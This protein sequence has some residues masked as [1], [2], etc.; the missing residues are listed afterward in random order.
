M[1]LPRCADATPAPALTWVD[2]AFLSALSRLLPTKLR[3]LRLV[4]PRTL[5]RWHA[6]L[7]AHR[8]SYPAR[9]SGRPPIPQPIRR[10]VSIP[11]RC[12]PN[13]SGENSLPRRPR[14]SSRATSPCR[15]RLPALPLHS[16]RDRARHAP[17]AYRGGTAHPTT[18][19]GPVGPATWL[20]DLE[21][22]ADQLQLLI[23]D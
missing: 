19:W 9:Q 18:A 21:D 15:H 4:S 7:V 8:W 1:L 13:R 6:Q 12:G 11:L 2:R 22:R 23:R 14:R 16:R 5:L 10:L 20:I 17:G 3:R